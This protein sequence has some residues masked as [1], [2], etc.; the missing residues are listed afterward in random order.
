MI[1]APRKAIVVAATRIAP[2]T[3]EVET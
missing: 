1:V 2:L 3:L